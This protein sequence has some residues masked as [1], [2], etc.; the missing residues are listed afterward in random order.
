MNN[1]SIGLNQLL[2]L[3]DS[4]FACDKRQFLKLHGMAFSSVALANL[5]AGCGSGSTAANGPASQSTSPAGSVVMPTKASEKY[6]FV[7]SRDFAE[8]GGWTLETSFTATVGAD[9]LVAQGFP[10][11][12][13]PARTRLSIDRAGSYSVFCR[14]KNWAP[15]YTPGRFKVSVNGQQ[16][17]Q[18]MGTSTQ[19]CWV[20]QKAGTV[21]LATGEVE[22]V[23]QDS[24]GEYGRCSSLLLTTD[25]D[26]VPADD[27]SHSVLLSQHLVAP[28]P[29][30]TPRGPFDFVVV[31]GGVAGTLAAV[32]AAR[33]G[34]RVA[35]LHNRPVL[36][37][38]ASDE[39]GVRPASAADYTPFARELGLI[40]ETVREAVG[41]GA[42]I[43]QGWQLALK[44]LCDN[45]PNLQLFLNLRVTEAQMPSPSVIG[46]VLA[47]DTLTGESFS[48]SAPLFADCTGDGNLGAL[49]GADFSYGRDPQSRYH[50][51]LAPPSAD[52]FMLG[53]TLMH[54]WDFLPQPESFRAPAWAHH[55][56]AQNLQG[57]DLPNP[58]PFWWVEHAGD[59]DI[60][61]QSE[62]VH[63]EL[64]KIVYGL[65]DYIKNRSP[66]AA[67][68]SKLRLRVKPVMGKRESRRLLGDLVLTEA[69]VRTGTPYQD[70][71]AFGGWPIDL[72]ALHGIYEP[73]SP[74]LVLDRV[75]PYGIPFRA[76]YSR[77]I[78][79]LMM[80]G[81]NISASHVALG[82]TRI[83]GTCGTLGQAIGTA[84]ALA[85]RYAITPRRVG[86][87]HLEELQTLLQRDDAVLPGLLRRE[88]G[89]LALGALITASSQLADPDQSYG[90]ENVISGVSRPTPEKYNAWV[91]DPGK[92]LPQWIQFE[93]A[94]PQVVA[95]LQV[96]FD[97]G[98]LVP[99]PEV[100]RDPLTVATYEVQARVAGIW[101]PV[102]RK[103]GNYQR[104]CNH[105]FPQLN[106]DAVRIV[107]VKT[108]GAASARIFEVRIFGP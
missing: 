23:L 86:Q 48:F 3:L 65:W 55:F 93:F 8:Y 43:N 27:I 25:A 40:E 37:G 34:S 107:V 7:A 96:C 80:A 94:Q 61:Q 70:V 39:V 5:L 20:W 32:A 35:L 19:A 105:R 67:Q 38:N 28:A 97:T 47:T 83:M 45:E 98:L 57:R 12:V 102:T 63:D 92:P 51:P 87:E 22:L 71:V 108:N 56:D 30:P 41:L 36:G 81:R 75:A 26:F 13:A 2:Q 78:S 52:H 11:T 91:S 64:L 21:Q 16:L 59:F 66:V 72:H 68:A 44:K 31:G 46:A 6:L 18:E 10:S 1:D 79:N 106:A 58:G 76:L 60:L 100:Q 84:A 82:S 14:C 99:R 62:E 29:E 33:H 54:S 17:T 90:P 101:V 42:T 103:T 85:G 77:N 50:E 69:D 9:Y 88:A 95:A 74:T 15:A 73:G 24:T 53:S 89:D 49:A 104:R 4:G